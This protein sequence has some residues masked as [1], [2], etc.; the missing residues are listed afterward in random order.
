MMM[1]RPNNDE[2]SISENKSDDDLRRDKDDALKV[3]YICIKENNF[4]YFELIF[5]SLNYT[6][7][8]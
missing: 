7:N 6:I 5:I 8:I 3:L 4:I 2:H 1:P